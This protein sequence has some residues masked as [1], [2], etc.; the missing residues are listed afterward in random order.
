MNDLLHVLLVP[1]LVMQV[2]LW[3]SVMISQEMA[4]G[5]LRMDPKRASF[6][7]NM[8]Y[9]VRVQHACIATDQR[10]DIEQLLL[11]MADMRRFRRRDDAS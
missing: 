8:L 4:V 11:C 10:G 9:D 1:C 6:A 5:I 7:A 3:V 2:L